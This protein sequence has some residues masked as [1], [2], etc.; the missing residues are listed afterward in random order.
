[1]SGPADRY[2]IF[3]GPGSPY[4]HKVRSVMRSRRI[5]H[6]WVIVQGGFDGT[7]QT[8]KL[9]HLRTQMFPIVQF[10]DGTPW[11]DSTPTIHELEKRHPDDA[12]SVLPPAP[13][14]RFLARLIEDFADEWL[15]LPLL[16]FGWT[17][18][19]NLPLDPKTPRRQASP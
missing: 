6:E 12:R 17:P 8:E 18:A 10:P 4:S 19:P 5:P 13:A 11:T 9:R 3:G 2:R 14:Q 16:A 1:M 7:G 15:P